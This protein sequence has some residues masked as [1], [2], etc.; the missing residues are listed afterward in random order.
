MGRTK[1]WDAQF[2]F[3]WLTAWLD[4][5]RAV[6]EASGEDAA[7]IARGAIEREIEKREKPTKNRQK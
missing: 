7:S 6:A 3:N 4:R 2:R 1:L 5:L